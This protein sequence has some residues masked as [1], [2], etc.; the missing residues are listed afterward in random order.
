MD[1]N[2]DF[3]QELGVGCSSKGYIVRA[4]LNFRAACYECALRRYDFEKGKG[5]RPCFHLCNSR[6]RRDH[7]SVYFIKENK[8]G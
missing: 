4:A 5:Y 6:D 3:L 7:E 8:D 1:K 2:L